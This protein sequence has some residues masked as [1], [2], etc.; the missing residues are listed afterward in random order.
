MK[1]LTSGALWADAKVGVLPVLASAAIFAGLAETLI[2]VGLT[3][4]ASVAWTAVAG[5]G[6]QAVLTRAVVTG[7]RVAL[8]DVSLTVLTRIA[9]R[10]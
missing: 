7:V 10:G 8:V 6:G 4:A 2:D 5:K 9:Y 3:Q 1:C